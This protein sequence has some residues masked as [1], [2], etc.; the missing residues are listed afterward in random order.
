MLN[1]RTSNHKRQNPVRQTA[2]AGGIKHPP[3]SNRNNKQTEKSAD[4]VKQN[5]PTNPTKKIDLSFHLR[6]PAKVGN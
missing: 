4:I 2:I 6:Q 5:I 3:I 1:S